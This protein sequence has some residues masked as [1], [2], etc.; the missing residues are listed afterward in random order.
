MGGVF[1]KKWYIAIALAFLLP[2]FAI[3]AV[4]VIEGDRAVSESENRALAQQPRFSFGALVSGEFAEGFDSYFSD[5]FPMREDLMSA[6]LFINRFY[7]VN[8][9]ENRITIDVDVDHGGEGQSIFDDPDNA[10]LWTVT[11]TAPPPTTV[12]T[13]SP[14]DTSETSEITTAEPV[15]EPEVTTPPRTAWQ[16]V[17]HPDGLPNYQGDGETQ[18]DTGAILILGD[19]AMEHFYGT[20]SA[21][22]T[23][24]SRV[25]RVKELLPDVEVYAMFCPTAMEFCAPAQ[26]QAGIRSQLRAMNYAYAHLAEGVVPVNVWSQLY[27][28]RDEYLYF[29]TDH[30][31]TQRGAYCAYLAFAR[32][33]GFKPYALEEYR[34]GAIGGFVGTMYGYT[35]TYPQSEALLNNPDTVE[36]FVPVT[37]CTVTRY[38]NADMTGGQAISLIYENADRFKQGAKYSAFLGGDS[39]LLHIVSD[40]VKNGRTLLVTKES[41][42]NALI[43]FLTDHFEEIYVVDPRSFN[44]SGKPSFDLVSFSV[45]HG[46]TDLLVVNYAFAACGP[47]MGSFAAMLP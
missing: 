39:P 45:G 43:P 23:Y 11:T 17:G 1:L 14:P 44:A 32:E 26:F 25:S 15:T 16:E 7:Y 4:A 20:N 38:T 18:K 3:F 8:F 28:R 46:V 10:D 2:V 37:T 5:Q 34:T 30:H 33:A 6:S 13:T 41:Y 31:W 22:E 12:T 19:R 24:A 35:K 27:A 47:Y 29:R 36:Y 9:G 42:G 21:L 40:T